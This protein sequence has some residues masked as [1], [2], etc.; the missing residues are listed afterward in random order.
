MGL[1]LKKTSSHRTL[2]TPVLQNNFCC[3]QLKEAENTFRQGGFLSAEKNFSF[4]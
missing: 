4:L 3:Y 2:G 1:V